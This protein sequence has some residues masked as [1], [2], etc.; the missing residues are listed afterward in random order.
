VKNRLAEQSIFAQGG[1]PQ[2][3][4]QFIERDRAQV[5]EILKVLSLQE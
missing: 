3:F 4:V 2:N 5:M 1:T